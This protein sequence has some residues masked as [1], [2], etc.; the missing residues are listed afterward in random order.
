MVVSLLVAVL[1]LLIELLSV[2]TASNTVPASRLGSR[3]RATGIT[4]IRPTVC[5]ALTLTNLV[6]G[7]K[8]ITGTSG[9]DL[10]LAARGTTSISGG[11]GNDCIMGGADADSIDGGGGTDVCVGS[12]TANYTSCATIIKN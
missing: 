11:N 1:V 2:T 7:T 3:T 10:I 6:T 5:A 8:K 12:R 4:E 9:A